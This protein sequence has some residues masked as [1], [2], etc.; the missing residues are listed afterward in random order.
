M[1][2]LHFV[3][4]W[5]KLS[6]PK[7]HKDQY[8]FLNNHVFAKNGNFV[9]IYIDFWKGD[10]YKNMNK[11]H[12]QENVYKFTC[13]ILQNFGDVNKRDAYQITR[14]TEEANMM[15]FLGELG[16]DDDDDEIMDDDDDD[17]E[18]M[19]TYIWK[20][21]EEDE[22][23]D[24]EDD[25]DYIYKNCLRL[26]NRV[27]PNS[28][29][30]N[31][32]YFDN[33]TGKLI[34]SNNDL[35]LVTF[36]NLVKARGQFYS[37]KIVPEDLL[38]FIPNCLIFL[39]QTIEIPHLCSSNFGCRKKYIAQ[40]EHYPCRGNGFDCNGAC[41][42]D[43]K[44]PWKFNTMTNT[45]ENYEANCK[46]IPELC[47]YIDESQWES[48][49][50]SDMGETKQYRELLQKQ[51]DEFQILLGL[52]RLQKLKAENKNCFDFKDLRI[53]IDMLMK[54]K[55]F[56]EKQFSSINRQKEWVKWVKKDETMTN[57]WKLFE[58]D[59]EDDSKTLPETE[60][61]DEDGKKFL[62]MMKNFKEL[63]E[64]FNHRTSSENFLKEFEKRR[65]EI[66]EFNSKLKE[67]NICDK[68]MKFYNVLVSRINRT[69]VLKHVFNTDVLKKIKN[70][71]KQ[72]TDCVQSISVQKYLQSEVENCNIAIDFLKTVSFVSR[73]ENFLDT[74]KWLDSDDVKKFKVMKNHLE[75]F[76]I[77][78]LVFFNENEEIKNWIKENEAETG[79][80]DIIKGKKKLELNREAYPNT[81][82]YK[83]VVKRFFKD[84]QKKCKNLT[85]ESYK[86]NSFIRELN[87][88]MIHSNMRDPDEVYRPII[89]KYLCDHS[90]Y[91]DKKRSFMIDVLNR[92]IDSLTNLLKETG[93]KK[94]SNI[95]NFMELHLKFD[96]TTFYSKYLNMSIEVLERELE[97][98]RKM[99][100][101]P[102][103]ITSNGS[104]DGGLAIPNFIILKSNDLAFTKQVIDSKNHFPHISDYTSD[105][106]QDITQDITFVDTRG[107]TLVKDFSQILFGCSASISNLSCF[108]SELFHSI[109][110]SPVR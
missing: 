28:L 34:F 73:I 46:N 104:F 69:L 31:I 100:Q 79:F 102:L 35:S 98:V 26:C 17:D 10:F 109:L 13:W 105:L 6:F 41:C 9:K 61:I 51:D 1:V 83:Q 78:N 20:L 5:V 108:I 23:D 87:A 106:T 44:L 107:H 47:L 101:D 12:A 4:Y 30:R 97:E 99:F 19:M 18:T 50:Y 52:T 93:C 75:S 56:L 21:F 77:E 54:C 81:T 43:A 67:Q 32:L 24:D 96:D 57:I 84:L 86:T 14:E 38:N 55:S 91:D 62:D 70:L 3:Y 22:D 15:K 27:I 25:D 58:E 8:D 71:H 16:M 68:S 95:F 80:Y 37:E 36:V 64:D 94:K 65:V 42:S 90:K 74:N 63:S 88:F 11:E 82:S 7:S 66:I 110:S 89:K 72:F 103:I 39:A 48:L 2:I 45:C 76:F 85:E 29:E 60:E 49:Y 59:E 92:K 33:K 40:L 53:T